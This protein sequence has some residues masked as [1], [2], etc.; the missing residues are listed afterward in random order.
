LAPDVPALAISPAPSVNVL[1]SRPDIS[2]TDD[3]P[4]EEL[5]V[6]IKEHLTQ[7]KIAEKLSEPDTNRDEWM[8][9]RNEQ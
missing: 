8:K 2:R 3:G 7:R 1:A 5:M 6:V 4:G 9:I